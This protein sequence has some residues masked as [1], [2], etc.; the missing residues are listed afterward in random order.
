[1]NENHTF[2]QD[3][4]HA[5]KRA[6]G[7]RR[8]FT[9]KCGPTADFAKARLATQGFTQQEK[10]DYNETFST[11][12]WYDRVRATL[13]CCC[14]KNVKVSQM[15]LTKAVVHDHID[16]AINMKQRPELENAVRP[17]YV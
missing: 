3:K 17:D 12:V 6:V 4:L 1:M 13:S 10:I 11:V 2:C 15:E 5:G 8:V 7:C 14:Y 16:A 9:S